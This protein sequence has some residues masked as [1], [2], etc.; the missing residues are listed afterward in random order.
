MGGVR[1]ISSGVS[2]AAGGRSVRAARISKKDT[3]DK[4]KRYSLSSRT[5]RSAAARAASVE[6]L[7]IEQSS[8]VWLDLGFSPRETANLEIRSNLIGDIREIVRAAGWTQA[9]AAKRCG[10]SQPRI[11]DLLRGKI[12]KFSIDALVKIGVSMGYRF[13]VTVTP[14]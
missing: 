9:E 13:E 10:I 2:G 4:P 7:Q 1:N 6:P 3:A 8:S 12:G 11:N 14:A 5:A